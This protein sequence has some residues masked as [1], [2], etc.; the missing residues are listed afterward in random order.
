ME[1]R[2][3]EEEITVVPI[4]PEVFNEEF[5]RAADFLRQAQEHLLRGN[6]RDVFNSCRQALEAVGVEN[7]DGT[8]NKNDLRDMVERTSKLTK[9]ERLMVLRRAT[10]V[11]ASLATHASSDLNLRTGWDMAD[12][13]SMLTMTAGMLQWVAEIR[14]S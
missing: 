13:R 11:M 10:F 2:Y 3:E 7:E 14:R 4:Y 12:A 6:C 1:G 5:E 9:N 8:G